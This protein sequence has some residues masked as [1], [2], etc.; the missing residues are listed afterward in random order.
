MDCIVVSHDIH[1]YATL[2]GHLHC[3]IEKSLSFYA[4]M[5]SYRKDNEMFISNVTIPFEKVAEVFGL[6]KTAIVV[7][8]K[9]H[10]E[11]ERLVVR[12]VADVMPSN[13]FLSSGDPLTKI[14]ES[15]VVKPIVEETPI[16]T[17]DLVTEEEDLPLGD[18]IPPTVIS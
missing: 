14:G 5:D 15:Y 3:G 12:I 10:H 4:K 7:G 9:E 18:I 1:I 6:P 16:V 8:V 2:N 13:S 11:G 17:G